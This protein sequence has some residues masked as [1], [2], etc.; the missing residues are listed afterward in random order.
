MVEFDF[1]RSKFFRLRF[2]AFCRQKTCQMG[3]CDSKLDKK[4]KIEKENTKFFRR[5]NFGYMYL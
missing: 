1:L 4:V 5:L 2:E 3:K